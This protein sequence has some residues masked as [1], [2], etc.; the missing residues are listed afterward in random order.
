[1]KPI[2]VAGT[3]EITKKPSKSVGDVVAQVSGI[4]GYDVNSIGG[5]DVYDRAAKRLAD[6]GETIPAEDILGDLR[7]E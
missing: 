1:M 6:A 4:L 3:T 2:A 5:P 7:Q